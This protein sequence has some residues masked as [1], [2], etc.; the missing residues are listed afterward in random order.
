MNFCFYMAFVSSLIVGALYIGFGNLIVA[1]TLSMRALRV[2][3]SSS[4]DSDVGGD[5]ANVSAGTP[6]HGASNASTATAVTGTGKRPS[7]TGQ[8]SVQKAQIVRAA[9][10]EEV[11][12]PLTSTAG[13][14]KSGGI[15]TATSTMTTTTASGGRSVVYVSTTA[16][17]P[18]TA[19]ACNQVLVDASRAIQSGK[20]IAGTNIQRINSSYIITF[21]SCTSHSLH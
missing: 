10:A 6:Q 4:G 11:D 20:P 5:S 14:S 15:Y 17:Q 2:P 1:Q 7:L 9:L 18:N 13:G 16:Q 21:F 12:D 8:N 19:V 3:E